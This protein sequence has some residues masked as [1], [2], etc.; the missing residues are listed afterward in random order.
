[1]KEQGDK[2]GEDKLAKTQD[3]MNIFKQNLE[4]FAI[5][6]KDRICTNPTFRKQFNDMCKSI[7][8]DPL[9]SKK[10]F[11]AEI[12]GIGDFYYDLGIQIIEICMLTREV[13]GGFIEMDLLI[14]TLAKKR[15][16]DELITS[17]DVERSIQKLSVLGNGFKILKMGK[18]EIVQSVGVELSSDH[19]TLMELAQNN[20]GYFSLESAQEN[21]KWTPE[22][23]TISINFFMQEGMVWLDAQDPSG[24][25]YYWFPNIV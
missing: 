5:K 21:L 4:L 11:W 23:I 12:L 16:Q 25:K 3:E 22:R 10:G 7:G 9:K 6:Y 14:A 13:N 19:T 24:K 18:R 20:D 17:S 8:V 1:M 15:G 2:I